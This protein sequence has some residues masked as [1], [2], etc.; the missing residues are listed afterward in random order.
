MT[1]SWPHEETLYGSGQ[2][3]RYRELLKEFKE[4]YLKEN[5]VHIDELKTH[6]DRMMNDPMKP[7]LHALHDTFI[8]LSAHGLPMPEEATD[9]KLYQL[10]RHAMNLWFEGYR[11]D[12]QLARLAIGRFLSELRAQLKQVLST[13]DHPL[14]MAV[15]SG[16]CH[17]LIRDRTI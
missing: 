9:E 6:F 17:L 11:L 5:A 3:K 4:N 7:S 14:K 16:M 8:A 12:K 10:E 1:L 2:C 13:S 15:Y